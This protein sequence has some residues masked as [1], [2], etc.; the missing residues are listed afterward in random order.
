MRWLFVGAVSDEEFELSWLELEDDF[1]DGRIVQ[2]ID[3]L[4]EWSVFEKQL[5]LI[6]EADMLFVDAAKDGVC[7]VKLLAN[8]E[9][10]NFRGSIIEQQVAM[11]TFLTARFPTG[12]R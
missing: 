1:A 2:H 5:P 9:K 8:F 10:A 3:D 12:G 6:E 7:E 4:T 11:I